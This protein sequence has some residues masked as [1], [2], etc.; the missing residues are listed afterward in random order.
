MHYFAFLAALLSWRE[1]GSE[2]V[3]FVGATVSVS[4]Y[5]AISCVLCNCVAQEL[6][7]DMRSPPVSS[8]GKKRSII[9]SQDAAPYRKG[10][11]RVQGRPREGVR[12]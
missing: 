4:L 10:T 11:E 2:T 5:L 12:R 7:K 6:P 8:E 3:Q 1:A 9:E